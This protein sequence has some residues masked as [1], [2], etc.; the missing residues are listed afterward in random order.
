[1]QFTIKKEVYYESQS[2]RIGAVIRIIRSLPAAGRGRHVSIPSNRGSHSN[3]HLIK[4]LNDMKKL[5]LNPLESGQSFEFAMIVSTKTFVLV[6]SQSPRIGAVIRIRK[7][8]IWTSLR[9]CCLNPLESGQSFEFRVL[10]CQR[11]R[12]FASHFPQTP[13]KKGLRG[14]FGGFSQPLI[15]RQLFDIIEYPVFRRPSQRP[16]KAISC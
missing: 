2:P 13:S 9:R 6:K 10:N 15:F 1:M 5:C 11:T 16:Q 12:P 4:I 8:L 14:K 7:S 3:H